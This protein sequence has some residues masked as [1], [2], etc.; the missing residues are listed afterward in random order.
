MFGFVFLEPEDDLIFI[1]LCINE[2]YVNLN[3]QQIGFVLHKYSTA[4]EKICIV[5][6]TEF[7]ENTEI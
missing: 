2:V 5:F 1:I 4:T 7:T 3:I 6:A